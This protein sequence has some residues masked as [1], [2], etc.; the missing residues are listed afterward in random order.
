MASAPYTSALEAILTGGVDLENDDI[1]AILIDTAD[2]TF[3]AAHDFLD[4]VPS[5][6]RVSTFTL[7]GKTVTGGTWDAT[8]GAWSSVTGDA[9]EAIILYVHTG[10]DATARLLFYLDG[11]TVTPNGGNINCAWHASGIAVFG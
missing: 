1:R 10:T 11:I 5:G 9:S 7:S 8:D 2:Y 3:S 6:A 4:D